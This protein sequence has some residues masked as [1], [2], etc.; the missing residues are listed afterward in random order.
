MSKFK[1][2]FLVLRGDGDPVAQ[3]NILVVAF[4]SRVPEERANRPRRF[5][6]GATDDLFGDGKA[7]LAPART[8]Y[9]PIWLGSFMAF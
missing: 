6:E 4:V 9:T 3:Q 5:H 7:G 8:V 1:P 2:K